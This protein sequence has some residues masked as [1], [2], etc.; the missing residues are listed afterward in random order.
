VG[1]DT[2]VGGRIYVED[3]DGRLHATGRYRRA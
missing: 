1:N 2:D 3:R